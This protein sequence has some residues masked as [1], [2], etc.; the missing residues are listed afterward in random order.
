VG[1]TKFIKPTGYGEVVFK[2]I[3][4]YSEAIGKPI[5]IS[6]RSDDDEEVLNSRP[7]YTDFYSIYLKSDELNGK[8]STEK[9][10][11]RLD[12]V[13]AHLVFKTDL[14][15]LH[16]IVGV[17]SKK[18]STSKTVKIP[19]KDQQIAVALYRLIA[20]IEDARVLHQWGLRYPG[21]A[22]RVQDRLMAVVLDKVFCDE[23]ISAYENADNE[24]T[25]GSILGTTRRFKRIVSKWIAENTVYVNVQ[26]LLASEVLDLVHNDLEYPTKSMDSAAD[27]ADSKLMES[28]AFDEQVNEEIEEAYKESVDEAFDSLE[29]ANKENG[30]AALTGYKTIIM[31]PEGDPEE[32]VADPRLVQIFR[33]VKQKANRRYDDSGVTVD[34]QR[35][36]GNRLGFTQ[37]SPFLSET[38]KAGFELVVLLDKSRSMIG[39]PFKTAYSAAQ[40]ILTAAKESGVDISVLGFTSGNSGELLIEKY[41]SGIAANTSFHS[42]PLH[43]AVDY[44]GTQFKSGPFKKRALLIL[45]D[46]CPNFT[47]LDGKDVDPKIV[48]EDLRANIRKL[49]NSRIVVHAAIIPTSDDVEKVKKTFEG[50]CTISQLSADRL[51]E[52]LIL[53]VL[54]MIRSL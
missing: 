35:V 42:T 51:K 5:G 52:D 6:L 4:L 30:I 25:H 31:H 28:H 11:D 2:T 53:S 20:S 13:L 18:L 8:Y 22:G 19:L 14:V 36:I 41:K 17:V 16:K 3:N 49:T 38:K 12:H 9:L 43:S 37:E 39:T 34:I 54:E 33:S 21:S 48:I 7:L 27:S 29:S 45:S 26:K 46:G 40:E 23:V 10:F 24:F 50:V 1:N 47:N 44:V 32:V 15:F